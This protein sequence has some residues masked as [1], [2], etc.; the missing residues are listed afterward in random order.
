MQESLQ[1]QLK[2]PNFMLVDFAKLEVPPQTHL[3]FIAL[4]RFV[5]RTSV[6][7][8]PRLVISTYPIIVLLNSLQVT[9]AQEHSFIPIDVWAL[10]VNRNIALSN[11]CV[12]QYH[13][14][15]LIVEIKHQHNSNKLCNFILTFILG[16]LVMP[17][18]YYNWQM[19]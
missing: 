7:P 4:D 8:K 9:Q 2:S 16:I 13:F 18:C 14:T 11:S 3:C 19:K 10:P 6:L 5:A 17:N 15:L 1:Q 12:E